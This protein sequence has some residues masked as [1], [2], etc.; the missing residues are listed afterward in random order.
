[1]M[2]IILMKTLKPFYIRCSNGCYLFVNGTEILCKN[3]TAAALKGDNKYKWYIF[4]D[5]F[6]RVMIENA[7]TKQVLDA[8]DGHKQ[9]TS[10]VDNMVMTRK[11]GD[12]NQKYYS[13]NM[14]IDITTDASTTV[15]SKIR[16]LNHAGLDLILFLQAGKLKFGNSEKNKSNNMFIF[17]D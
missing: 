14:V 3:P 1:M 5:N 10:S 15:Y 6:G 11:V 12:K 7:A 17:V 9:T 8:F 16:P 13:N 2:E 4:E